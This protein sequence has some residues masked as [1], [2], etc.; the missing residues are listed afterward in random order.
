MGRSRGHLP[1]PLVV[2]GGTERGGDHRLGHAVTGQGHAPAEVADR[3]RVDLCHRLP[4]RGPLGCRGRGDGHDRARSAHD[5]AGDV[6]GISR[7]SGNNARRPAGSVQAGAGRAGAVRGHAGGASAGPWSIRG[8]PARGS[9]GRCRGGRRHGVAAGGPG[10]A[11]RA[12]AGG[13]V[14]TGQDMSIPAADT[15]HADADVLMITY[16]RPAYTR[17]ALSELLK[18]SGPSTRVWVWQNGDDAETLEV[19]A[20]F[21]SHLFRYHHSRENCGLTKPTNW[22]FENARGRYLSKVDDD[23]IVPEQWDV[24]LAQAHAD[25]PRFGVI[26]CWRFPDEDFFPELAQRKIRTFA[27]GH[28]LMVNMWVEGSGYL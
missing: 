17:L 28:Q 5:A 15:S 9:A 16:N 19:V 3:A 6:G 24:K 10:E 1:D 14:S 18:R 25:E 22:L 2:R 26:G 8:H 11:R 4:H 7:V 27:R 23:C 12:S 21:R 13:N 20:G